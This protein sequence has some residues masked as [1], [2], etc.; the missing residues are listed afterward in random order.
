MKMNQYRVIVVVRLSFSVQFFAK[1]SS[2]RQKRGPTVVLASSASM[3]IQPA[4]PNVGLGRQHAPV[5][6]VLS[7]NCQ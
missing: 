7:R 3:S 5:A 6:L 1:I 4:S 2:K